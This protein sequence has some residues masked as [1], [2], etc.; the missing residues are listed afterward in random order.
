MTSSCY[1]YMDYTVWIIQPTVVFK[2]KTV[3]PYLFIPVALGTPDESERNPKYS[4]LVRTEILAVTHMTVQRHVVQADRTVPDFSYLVLLPFQ[5][6]GHFLVQDGCWK[7][8]LYVHF[9]TSR[10]EEG[11]R[12]DIFMSLRTLPR[13]WAV[14]SANRSLASA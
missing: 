14:P 8:I 13:N 11:R 12:K 1:P 2:F 6:Q 4:G 5:S 9:P 10:K 7:T 3:F